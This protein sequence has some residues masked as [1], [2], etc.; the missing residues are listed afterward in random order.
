M[1]MHA[2]QVGR[3]GLVRCVTVVWES[4]RWWERGSETDRNGDTGQ[5]QDDDG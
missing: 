2:R 3:L 4:K 1:M 5:R